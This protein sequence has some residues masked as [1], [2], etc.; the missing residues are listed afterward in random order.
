M[1]FHASAVRYGDREIRTGQSCY[2]QYGAGAPSAGSLTEP[3]LH[4]F[5]QAAPGRLIYDPFA[6]T[7]SMLYTAAHFGALVI[8]SDLDGRPMRGHRQEHAS[9][10]WAADTTLVDVFRQYNV[11]PRLTGCLVFDLTVRLAALRPIDRSCATDEVH[12]NIPGEEEA[13]LMPSYA[14]LPCLLLPHLF[15]RRASDLP[16]HSMAFAPAQSG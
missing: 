7:G 11:L 16:M 1:S 9:A 4:R 13:S 12:S 8:G 10:K 5:A 3:L 14:I 6:G 2:G 15:A